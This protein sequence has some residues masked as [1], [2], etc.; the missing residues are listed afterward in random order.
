MT[1]EDFCYVGMKVKVINA[2]SMLYGDLLDEY[3]ALGYIEI[4]DIFEN[5]N[6]RLSNGDLWINY[7]KSDLIPIVDENILTVL[8]RKIKE[9]KRIDKEIRD[10]KDFIN[11]TISKLLNEES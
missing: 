9:S 11:D 3:N 10:I 1:C 4:T 7:H 5:G 2:G 6:V 8:D